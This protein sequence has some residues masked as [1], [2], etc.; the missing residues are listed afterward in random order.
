MRPDTENSR[1][2]GQI[3]ELTISIHIICKFVFLKQLLFLVKKKKKK[4]MLPVCF[5]SV[6]D[7]ECFIP[8]PGGKKAPVPDLHWF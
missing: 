4:R 3:E 1:I 8:D 5:S 2:Y 7:P 6:A